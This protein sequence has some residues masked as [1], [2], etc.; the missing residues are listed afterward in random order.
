MFPEHTLQVLSPHLCRKMVSK[1]KDFIKR[2]ML[3]F[4]LVVLS[5]FVIPSICYNI[6]NESTLLII[7]LLVVTLIICLL[8]ML[9]NKIHLRVPLFRYLIELCM[10]LVTL[11]FFGWLWEWYMPSTVWI[12]FVMVIP[13]YVIAVL[14]DAVRVK[15]DVEFINRNIKIRQQKRNE[16]I[17][18]KQ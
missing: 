1:V 4:A 2:W 10:V 3:I 7:K 18:R 14:L 17:T 13:V 8:Q 11:L 5:A 15:R 12:I 16:D 9:T 6:W